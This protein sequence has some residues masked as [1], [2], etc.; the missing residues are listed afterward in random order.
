[1]RRRGF[2]VAWGSAA[3]RPRQARAQQRRPS[4]VTLII[5]NSE[6]DPQGPERVKAFRESL[7]EAGWIDGGNATIEVRWLA[8]NPDRA[9]GYAREVTANPPDVVVVN[10][11]PGLSALHRL[12]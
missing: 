12:N 2:M 6:D 9:M 1:M 4:R 8:Q 5:A 10:G 7:R 11:T 3:I